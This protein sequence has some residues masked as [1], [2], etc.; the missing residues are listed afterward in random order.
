[1]AST[2]R[3]PESSKLEAYKKLREEARQEGLAELEE[4]EKQVAEKRAELMELGFIKE[5]STARMARRAGAGTRKC[6]ICGEPNHN[7]RSCPQK[8]KA[9]SAKA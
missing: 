9:A 6:S 2:K 1:M 5:D 8:A 3:S 4:L 7:S